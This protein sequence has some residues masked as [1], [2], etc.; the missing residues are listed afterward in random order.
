MNLQQLKVSALKSSDV[1]PRFMLS[2]IKELA[3]SIKV[4]GI[5]E[6]LVVNLEIDGAYTILA[7]HRRLAAAE[8]AGLDLV[9]C[10]VRDENLPAGP[11]TVVHLV[12]NIQRVDLSP[13]ETAIAVGGALATGIKAKDLAK[14][15][16]RSAAWVSKYST[17]FKAWHKLEKEKK[18]AKL[19]AFV[20]Q[21]DGDKLYADAQSVLGLNKKEKQD[22]LL[23]SEQE[24]EKDEE[25]SG[26]ENAELEVIAEF[27][28][29][30]HMLE[31]HGK[32]DVEPHGK[33]GFR[34]NFTFT[35]EAKARAWIRDMRDALGDRQAGV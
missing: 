20:T 15:V 16:G 34:I 13:M 18:E 11:R 26:A 28:Q 29:L 24:S 6:P 4:H 32:A 27:R 12:E 9:P 21:T 33:A 3:D 31:K 23:P 1:N 25:T 7:G 10:I 30:L 19:Q 8:K 22:D 5:I 17:I 35:N 2:D 14:Q